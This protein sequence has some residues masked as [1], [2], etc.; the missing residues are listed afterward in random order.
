MHSLPSFSDSYLLRARNPKSE[1]RSPR[2]EARNPWPE[3]R[4]PRPD[5]RS[6]MP[7]ARGS[8]GRQAGGQAGRWQWPDEA[9]NQAGRLASWRAGSGPTRL[10][11]R[12]AGWQAGTLASRQAGKLCEQA[13]WLAVARRSWLAGSRHVLCHSGPTARSG[14]YIT[15]ACYGAQ[16]FLF[17]DST[18]REA[19]PLERANWCRN[20]C[21]DKV[22]M[23]AYIREDE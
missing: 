10:A 18:R 21:L 7:E 5:T 20:G 11:S 13:S 19:S 3:A 22:Y 8:L 17:D 14:H 2:P 16:W 9:G 15:F 12:Q 23:L 4:S 6:P 1:T